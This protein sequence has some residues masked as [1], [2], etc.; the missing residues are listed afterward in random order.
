MGLAVVFDLWGTLVHWPEDDSRRLRARWA[1]RLGVTPERLDE[2]WYGAGAY[3]ERESGPLRPV[4]QAMA[5][6]L[7]DEGIV[8]ELLAWRLDFARSALTVSRSIVETLDELRGRGYRLGLVSNCTEDVA[9]VWSATQLAPRFDAAVFSA[10]AGCLKPDPR[11]YGLVC[12]SL[13]AEPAECLFVG[14]GAND[15]L[16]GAERIGMTPVLIHGEGEEPRWEG[17][18]DW[19]GRRVTSISQVLE[20]VE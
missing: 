16:L 19:P 5:A 12:R 6:Q 8:D 18:A 14:D 7:G 11:I 13:D 9:I 3:E 1:A 4:L 10:R 20:L 15:E 2:L 17:L